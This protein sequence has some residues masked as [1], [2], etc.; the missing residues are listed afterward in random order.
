MAVFADL[1]G[2]AQTTFNLALQAT[3]QFDSFPIQLLKFGLPG[4][5]IPGIAAL[6]PEL[7]LETRL[8]MDMDIAAQMQVK[9]DFDF[10]DVKMVFPEGKGASQA[11]SKPVQNKNCKC[12]FSIFLSLLPGLN[13][14]FLSS[15][16]PIHRQRWHRL[17]RH[18]RSTLDPPFR[19]R[20]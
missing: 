15:P 14:L 18:S 10:G 5:S 11:S 3:G 1:T 2:T 9:A 20:Y 8:K 16:L 17:Q 4:L 6:G 7:V 12:P 13:S 19:F